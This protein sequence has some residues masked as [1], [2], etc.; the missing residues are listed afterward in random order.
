MI[1]RLFEEGTKRTNFECVDFKKPNVKCDPKFAH[2]SNWPVR[3]RVRPIKGG[4]T[5]PLFEPTMYSYWVRQI[6]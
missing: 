2:P 1:M 3:V 5:F 6:C 4:G